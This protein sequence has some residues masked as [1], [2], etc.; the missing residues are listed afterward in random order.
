MS[1]SSL[2]GSQYYVTFIDDF[3]RYTTVYFLKTKDEVLEKFKEF[4]SFAVKVLRTDNGGEY[5]SKLFDAFLKEKG[6]IHQLSVPYNPAQNRVAERMNHTVVECARSMLSHSNMP[7]VFWA[8]AVNTAV[9]LRNRSPTTALKETTPYECLFKRKPDVA[10]LKVFGCL[11]LVHI[12][13][14]QQRSL[15]QSHERQYLLDIQ[16]MLKDIN[17]MIQYQ[18]NFS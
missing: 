9:Y 8:E 13:D 15:K 16:I 6:I 5:C 11:L 18:A 10:N 7:N 2:G 12:P 4:H 3:T 14:N 17:Y 1:V